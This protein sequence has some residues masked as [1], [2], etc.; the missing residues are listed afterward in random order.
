MKNYLF[1]LVFAVSGSWSLQAQDKPLSTQTV[2]VTKTYTPAIK[3][4]KKI[5]SEPVFLDSVFQKRLPIKLSQFSAPV[6]STFSPV[7]GKAE[8]VKA[9]PQPERFNSRILISAGNYSN[10]EVEAFTRQGMG[11]SRNTYTLGIEHQSSGGD[12]LDNPLPTDF[13]SNALQAGL[14]FLGREGQGQIEMEISRNQFH[15]YG[16]DRDRFSAETL[17]SADVQQRYFSGLLNGQ[18][19]P[20]DPNW[21]GIQGEFHFMNDRFDSEETR[22]T[23][24]TGFLLEID[25][26][27]VQFNPSVDWVR[28]QMAANALDQMDLLLP[29]SYSQAQAEAELV[30]SLKKKEWDL[31]IGGAVVYNADE[32]E[33]DQG[34]SFY[35][36]A[37]GRYPLQKERHYLLVEASGGLRQNSYAAASKT[38]PFVSPTLRIRPSQQELLLKGGLQGILSNTLSYQLGVSVESTDNQALFRLNPLNSFRNPQEAY[39]QGNSYQW[40][41]Q[42]LQRIGGYL[43]LQWEPTEDF[44]FRTQWRLDDYNTQAWNLPN[45]QGEIALDWKFDEQWLFSSEVY[46]IGEREDLQSQVV[47][48]V[49]PGEFPSTLLELESILDLNMQLEYQ[50]TPQW[51]FFV[52][53]RNLTNQNYTFF[54]QYPVQGLQI[55]GG[56][57]YR[58]DW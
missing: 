1:L 48:G 9:E 2:T 55:L 19:S 52:K 58:F 10:I 20:E 27:E 35:P 34:F 47:G 50:W 56:A 53:G 21:Q 3:P 32:S 12:I 6:A 4:A 40:I 26:M 30:W 16:F 45:Y 57:R 25:E 46:I 38:N 23:L 14:Q 37:S 15:W 31:Q 42:D 29:A 22:V 11:N 5:L 7:K 17:P 54:A 49:L 18:W 33:L 8:K 24:S 51:S 28:G 13:S 36:R 44:S 43:E 39:A 41:Y